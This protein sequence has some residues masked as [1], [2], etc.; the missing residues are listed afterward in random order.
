MMDIL[1]SNAPKS[2]KELMTDQGFYPQTA[3]TDQFVEICERAATEDT[4]R[5][6]KNAPRRHQQQEDF[7]EDN[8]LTRK[9]KKKH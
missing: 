7:S 9:P 2:H 4:L 3:T 8:C 6:N 5:T 1:A